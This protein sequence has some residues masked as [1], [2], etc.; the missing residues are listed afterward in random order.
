MISP[1][2]SRIIKSSNQIVCVNNVKHMVSNTLLY[3]DDN[4]G[5][6]QMTYRRLPETGTISWDD[7][8]SQYDGRNLTTN[9]MRLR[10]GFLETTLYRCP[11]DHRENEPRDI[12]RSYGINKVIGAKAQGED[13]VI[14]PKTVDSI[15]A[16][17]E[18][19]LFAEYPNSSS[20]SLKFQFSETRY[21]VNDNRVGEFN[22]QVGGGRRFLHLFNYRQGIHGTPLHANYGLVDGS[23]HFMAIYD[24]TLGTGLDLLQQNKEKGTYFD[25]DK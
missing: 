18:T 14:D 22:S 5:S 9:E 21:R 7:L 6:F 23:A 12:S 11:E 16:P 25:V 8:L 2:L 1:S 20:L 24:L 19:I 15:S 13:I 10:G 3:T 17:S 4:H